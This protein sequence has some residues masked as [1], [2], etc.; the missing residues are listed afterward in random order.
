MTKQLELNNPPPLSDETEELLV[1]NYAE[2][3]EKLADRPDFEAAM[4]AC[5]NE[6]KELYRRLSKK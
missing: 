3:F 6:N 4:N 2:T 5:L 1:H